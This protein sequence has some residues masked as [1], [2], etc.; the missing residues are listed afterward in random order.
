MTLPVLNE[1]Y[2]LRY[3]S[4]FLGIILNLIVFILFVLSTML[5][6]NLLLVSIETKTF[7]LGVLRVQGLNKI[8]VVS[9]IVV[10]SLSYVLPAIIIGLLLS[11]PG[12]DVARGRLKA[13]IGNFFLIFFF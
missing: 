10:Q 11:I 3:A 9:L 5:L 1:L 13:A 7:E 6:Y 12:L 2:G 8:G 4:M